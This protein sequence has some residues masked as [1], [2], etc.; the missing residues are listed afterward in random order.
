[1]RGKEQVIFDIKSEK[2]KYLQ[3]ESDKIKNVVNIDILNKRLNE[4]KKVNIYSNIKIVVF[5]ILVVLGFS[6]ISLSY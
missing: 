4:I 3:R 5:S 6:L 2:F 1:M